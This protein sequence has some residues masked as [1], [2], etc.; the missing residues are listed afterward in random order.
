LEATDLEQKSFEHGL[1]VE[2]RLRNSSRR[3]ANR[4]ALRVPVCLK[5]KYSGKLF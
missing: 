2:V 3:V 4:V 1:I 5:Q